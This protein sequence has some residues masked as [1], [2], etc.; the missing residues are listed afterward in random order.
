[1]GVVGTIAMLLAFMA[2]ALCV[3]ATAAGHGLR[4]R[5]VGET[6]SWAARVAAIVSFVGLSISIA[7]LACAFLTNYLDIQYVLDNHVTDA[8]LLIKLS[9]VWAGRQ[10][11]LLLWAWLMSLFGLLVSVRRMGELEALDN[12]ASGI[13]QL[14]IAAFIGIMLFSE[15]GSPFIATSYMYYADDGSLNDAAYLTG[16]NMLLQ[17]WAMAIHPPTL[18]AGYAGL[19]VPFAYALAA[20]ICNRPDAAWVVRCERY[21][22]VSWVFLT[23]GIGLGAVWAYVCLGWGGYWG[24]DPVENASL[25]A[26]LVC[27]ALLH[28][29]KQYQ[30][31]G[32]FKCWALMCAVLAFA[33]CIVGTF[34]TRSGLVESV[35]AF[36]GDPVSLGVFGGL[37]IVS[38]VAGV[39]ACVLRRKSFVPAESDAADDDGSMLSRDMAFYV[40]NLI[41]VIM[42]VL[43][44]YL[45][46]AQALPSW[47]PFGG[48][49]IS[50]GTYN[51]IARPIGILYLL[52]MAAC[53][54]L[55]WR[56]TDPAAFAAKAKVPS[57]CAAVLF[58][59]LCAYA[60][61]VLFPAYDATVAAGGSAAEDLA[62]EGPAFY[63]K[64]ITI[65]GFAVAA[66]LL[67]NCLFSLVRTVRSGAVQRVRHIGASVSHLAMGVILVGLICSNM[68]VTEVSGYVA[69]DPD[70]DTATETFEIGSYEL[71]YSSYEITE[72]SDGTSETYAIKLNV[73]KDGTFLGY[74]E[75]SIC[76]D[77][78]TSQQQLNAGV[79]HLAGEDLFVVFQGL[80]ADNDALS[81]DVRINPMINLV[82]AGLGL[83]LAGMLL[84]CLGRK[85]SEQ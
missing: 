42:A 68:Y 19:T 16:M 62:A 34:I 74:V 24:W 4:A 65:V 40:N 23:C 15:D 50:A 57:V 83:L 22:Q 17:H 10:G 78:V 8:G 45:T 39:V 29:F 60:A 82:W 3:V 55:G 30:L 44:A 49:S 13:I 54:L 75:P 43:L 12:I 6:L 85:R 26:W 5:E 9:G 46:I 41:M 2:S 80:S 67:M 71:S 37:I 72:S 69:Y 61:L 33:F 66:L 25:L 63:Y 47:L 77:M 59:V 7:V 38:I 11:S 84:S 36:A 18:F 64:A 52:M 79:L 53:P 32:Q 51:A 21:A 73:R 48:Q 58:A 28:S 20:A 81:L 1:M 35:H 76:M 70:T 31:R 14:V 56:K 27:V